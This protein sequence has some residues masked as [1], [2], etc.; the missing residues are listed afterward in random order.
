MAVSFLFYRSRDSEAEPAYFGAIL[1]GNP[2]AI[3]YQMQ[4]KDDGLFDLERWT[5]EHMSRDEVEQI[6]KTRPPFEELWPIDSPEFFRLLQRYVLP[7]LP[8]SAN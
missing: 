7:P 5:V 2:Y 3:H 1:S 4:L 8:V 6:G